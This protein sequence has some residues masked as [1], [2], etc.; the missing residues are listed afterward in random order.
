MA[1]IILAGGKSTR[2]GGSDKAFLPIGEETMV[3]MI[4]SQ[5]RSLF[6]EIVVVA[7]DAEA[8]AE[9]PVTVVTDQFPGL[10]PIGGIHAGLLAS[11]DKYNL[12]LACDLPLMRAEL[13]RLLLDRAMGSGEEAALEQDTLPVDVVIP[14]VGGFI[15]PTAA[16]YVRGILPTVEQFIHMGDYKLKNLISALHTDYVPEAELRR[17]DPNL[18][19]FLNVNTPEEYERVR[20]IVRL[21]CIAE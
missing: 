14:I 19:S 12:V 7:K 18:E 6:S 8:Y 21:R 15:E 3:G 4:I 2:M 20:A 9:M 5:F 17:V 10:G 16:V 1:L 13:V 11:S